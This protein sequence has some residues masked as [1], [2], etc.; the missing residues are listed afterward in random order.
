MAVLNGHV[1]FAWWLTWGDA[2]HVNPYELT[3]ITIPDPWLDCKDTNKQ[4]CML[5]RDL[6][7]TIIPDNIKLSQSGTQGNKFENVNFHE[8]CPNI[9]EEIDALF[10]TSLGLPLDPLL[11]ELRVV[12]SD[13]SWR[14]GLNM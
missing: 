3:S 10:L 1:A 8:T 9:V 14:V 13:N 4:A 12:R 2:F 6:I 5:G 7:D 11:D